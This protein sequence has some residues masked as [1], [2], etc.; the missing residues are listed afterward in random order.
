VGVRRHLLGQ[1]EE[2]VSDLKGLDNVGS[3]ASIPM[4]GEHSWVAVEKTDAILC[5]DTPIPGNGTSDWYIFSFSFTYALPESCRF[6]V[7]IISHIVHKY[8]YYYLV[9]TMPSHRILYT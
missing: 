8:S 2:L 1:W 5:L 4:R 7:R 9:C 6:I 3:I